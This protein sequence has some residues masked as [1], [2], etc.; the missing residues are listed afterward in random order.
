MIRVGTGA[1]EKANVGDLVGTTKAVI[2]EI[3]TGRIVL[4]ETFTDKDGRQNRALI[5]INEGE[6][7]GTRYLQR[8][9]E[10]RFTGTTLVPVSPAAPATTKT[11]PKK[12]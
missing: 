12:P 7:G 5:V 10:P 8:S 2:K 6:R 11:P 3:S 4:E 1:L 9:D